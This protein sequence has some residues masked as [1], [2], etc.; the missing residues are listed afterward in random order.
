MELSLLFSM[1]RKNLHP[2]SSS[3]KWG[4]MPFPMLRRG[5]QQKIREMAEKRAK[6]LMSRAKKERSLTTS[7]M[8]RRAPRTSVG[9]LLRSSADAIGRRDYDISKFEE[10]LED[11]W[12]TDADEL[13][14]MSVDILKSYMPRRLAE[15][16]HNQ[17]A[18]DELDEAG[19]V[20]SSHIASGFYDNKQRVSWKL[21]DDD[22]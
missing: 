20:R 7:T 22:D 12:Y 4:I 19:G 13:K 15:E 9:I 16:V 5:G 1:M 8:S 17:L 21:E 14:T 3:V 10:K 6:D 2:Y 11:D 18:M